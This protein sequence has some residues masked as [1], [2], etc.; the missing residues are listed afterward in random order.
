MCVAL[1]ACAPTGAEDVPATT[2]P[3]V[4]T[5]ATTTTMTSSTTAV[6]TTTTSPSTTTVPE[7]EVPAELLALIGAPMPEV[8]LTIEGPEDVER[9]IEEF[10]RWEAW[11][12]A[13]PA[14]GLATLENVAAGHYLHTQE[15]GLPKML[16]ARVVSVGGGLLVR[17][18]EASFDDAAV[19]ILAVVFETTQASPIFTL[20]ADT[21]EVVQTLEPEGNWVVSDAILIQGREG[22]WLLSEFISR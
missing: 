4:T 18:A 3:A 7:S 11:A 6:P 9:W 12:A 10:L 1:V 8:D 21:L 2:A 5:P 15:E 14:K 19:G 13:N 20:D 16:D 22:R 17:R